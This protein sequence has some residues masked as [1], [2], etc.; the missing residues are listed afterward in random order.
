MVIFPLLSRFPTAMA[1]GVTTEHTADALRSL[2]YDVVIITPKRDKNI[3]SGNSVVTLCEY[4]YSILLSNRIKK[5]I[6]IRLFFFTVIYGFVIN[7]KYGRISNIF[8]T[9]DLFLSCVLTLITRSS[10]VCEIHRTPNRINLMYLLLLKKRKNVTL[11]PISEKLRI[12]LN[13]QENRSVVVPM[14]VNQKDILFFSKI[15]NLRKKRI[16]YLGNLYSGS[17]K[18]NVNLLNNLAWRLFSKFPDWSIEVIGIDSDQFEVSCTR[19]I[20]SNLKIIGRLSRQDIIIKLAEAKIGL[21]IYSNEPYFHDSFPIKIVEYAAARLCIVASDTAAHRNILSEDTCIY[22]DNN[23]LPSLEKSI[24]R[25]IRDK[26]LQAFL[27]QNA[28]LWAKNLTYEKR[29]NSVL[30][31]I[32]LQT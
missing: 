26:K 28:F 24:T 18:L 22:F 11:A 30:S 25:L 27:S 6:G 16:V 15:K 13:L 21:V 19:K 3:L 23:S 12:K 17:Y 2:N 5:L 14:S 32:D 10:I 4:F 20:P 9:R 7:F 29:I 31:Q 1:Y 8:W